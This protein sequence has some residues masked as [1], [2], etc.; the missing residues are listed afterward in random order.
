[1][2]AGRHRA[3]SCRGCSAVAVSLQGCK[4][5]AQLR[6]CHAV[7]TKG[8]VVHAILSSFLHLVG[9]SSLRT[10]KLSSALVIRFR[11]GSDFAGRLAAGCNFSVLC[12]RA[13]ACVAGAQTRAATGA[14]HRHGRRTAR[15]RVDAFGWISRGKSQVRIQRLAHLPV[16]LWRLCFVCRLSSKRGA[17]TNAS[18]SRV[19]A[20]RP[21]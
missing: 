20:V 19:G 18:F 11:A 9:Q 14:T 5:P 6:L 10:A 8:R 3:L 13:R 15:R 17:A 1:V 7:C 4:Q 21:H 2:G 12:W 16:W